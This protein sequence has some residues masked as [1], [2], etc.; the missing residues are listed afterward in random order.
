MRTQGFTL[1]HEIYKWSLKTSDELKKKKDIWWLQ[2]RMK[3]KVTRRASLSAILETYERQ[4]QLHD[5]S[6]IKFYCC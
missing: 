4:S 6:V 5:S 2:Q 3:I 1:T